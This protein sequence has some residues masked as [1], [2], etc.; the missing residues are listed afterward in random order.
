MSEHRA[1]RAAVGVFDVSHLGKLRVAGE[2]AG[3]AL[4][5]AVTA[6]VVSLPP[7]RATYALVCDDDGGCVD[8]VFVYRL[9]DRTWLVVPNTANVDAVGAALVESGV[10][11]VDE[12][13]RWAILA[14]QGPRSFE[15]FRSA[16]PASSATELRLHAFE[17]LDV[18]RESRLQRRAGVLPTNAKLAQV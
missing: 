13:D 10:T 15:V 8:D 3:D 4:Q 16:F 5:R 12:W 14:L 9:D 1:V 2:R 18:G 7:G 11:P 17:P 6:D